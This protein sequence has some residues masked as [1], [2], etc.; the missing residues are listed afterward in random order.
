MAENLLKNKAKKGI[1]WSSI[2]RLS[3][4]GIQFLFTIILARLLSPTDY[5]II[6]MPMIFLALAQ[7]FI[8]SGFANALIRKIDLKEEDLSTAFYFNVLVGI[9]CYFL[10]FFLS[11]LIA[12]FYQ[13]PILDVLLK[14][15][16]LT[17]LVNPLCTIQQ[18]LLT[19]KIDFKTQAI[20]SVLSSLFSGLSGVWMA[21]HGYGVWSLVFQQVSAAFARVVLLW[22]LSR[23]RPTTRWSQESFTYL[24]GYGSKILGVGLLDT[25]YNNVYPLIIGKFYTA[26]D[27]GNYT[28]AQQFVDL[29]ISNIT[30]ILQ[31][32]TFPVLSEMQNE[33][34]RLHD[35]YLKLIRVTAL[36]MFPL[37]IA[38]ASVADPFIKL[39]LGDKWAECIVFLQ[40][41]CIAKIWSPLNA[42]N[43][44]LLQVKGRSD[45]Y[46]QVEIIKKIIMTIVMIITVPLGILWMISGYVITTFLAFLINIY[47]TRKVIGIKIVEQI[48]AVM[49]I[50]FLSLSMAFFIVCFEHFIEPLMLKLLGGLIIGLSFFYLLCIGLKIQAYKDIRIFLQNSK[51]K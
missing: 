49:P 6:A 2:E 25:I 36:V 15:T 30:G 29:P 7:V 3:S 24:W 13:T 16:A 33:D 4:Q 32:V 18:T 20:V 1:V 26:K 39:L 42:V 21:Y 14:V 37:M 19:K 17:I 34:E 27:L 46:L 23:W 43:L 44:N 41:L 48:K 28:R 5:G 11:P 40:I 51:I 50:L 35:N 9:G 47:F 8:D 12:K 10:L 22:S 31:R 45:L 38:L